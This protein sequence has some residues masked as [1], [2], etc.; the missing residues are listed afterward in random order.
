[1]NRPGEREAVLEILTGIR[2]N[3]TYSHIAV[4]ETL[5]RCEREGMDRRQRAFV[6]RLTEGVIERRIELDDILRRYAKKGARIRPVIRDILRMGVFQILYMDSVP[7]SAA[8]NEAVK[9]TKKYGKKE[10]SGF[11]NGLLRSVA[12][13]KDAGKLAVDSAP[14][15]GDLSDPG[16]LSRKYSMPEWIVSMW[17]KQLGDE[18]T[19]KLLEVLLEVRPVAIRFDDRCSQPR[20]EE[21][22]EKMAEKGVQV[23][24][25]QYLPYC[26]ELTGTD[27]IQELPGYREG[28]WTVQDE[29]SMMVA[30]AAGL[31]GGETDACRLINAESDGLPGVV[32]DFYAGT[33]VVQ[34]ATA[35]AEFWK[36]EIACAL[37]ESVP[38]CVGV[39]NRS[40]VA[41][42]ER[43]GL[44]QETG[45]LA[46]AEPPELIEIHEGAIRFL[47]DVRK[48]H[49]TGFYLDQRD[50]RAAVGALGCNRD[51]LNC[52]SYTGGFGLACRAAGAVSVRHVDM[53]PRRHVAGRARPRAE[54]HGF[55]GGM[56]LRFGIRLRRRL[57]IPAPP[58][59]RR[60]DVRPDNPRP[61]EVRGLPRRRDEGRARIQGHQPAR[62]EAS[63]PRRHTCHVLVLRRGFGGAVPQDRRR[64]GAGRAARLPDNRPHLRAGGPSRRALLPGGPL[65]ER[66]DPPHGLTCAAIS[67]AARPLRIFVL[68]AARV[69]CYHIRIPFN[70]GVIRFRRDVS[71]PDCASRILVGLVK[72]REKQ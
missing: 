50:A 7:D 51:V 36:R 54:K 46:G 32:A 64:S 29:S 3:G 40:D 13:D 23:R 5:D 8:C 30:E 6:K 4:K 49:K 12:R 52:F 25:G 34:L 37:M 2:E 53:S 57:Q 26:Y 60:Q 39:W 15:A 11:V 59:R 71:R 67:G 63:A 69:F 44:S 27:S 28:S 55:D 17:K 31:S 9:L 21:I 56:L 19:Q 41:A 16:S 14:A 42:R 47:V 33:A 43:E 38:G 72:K 10:L 61:A 1:M 20:R 18:E 70:M 22:L 68:H 58:A 35:G 65:P 24:K 66:P 45:L 62:D 48:G